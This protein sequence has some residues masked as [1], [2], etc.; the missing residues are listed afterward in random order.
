MNSLTL[1]IIMYECTM[2][3]YHIH[4]SN[5]GAYEWRAMAL[6]FSHDENHYLVHMVV[7]VTT[8]VGL[9]CKGCSYIVTLKIL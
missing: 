4:Y 2:D 1:L 8:W 6:N 3:F 7:H 5:I 9:G